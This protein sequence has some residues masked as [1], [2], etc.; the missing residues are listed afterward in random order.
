MQTAT[1][2]MI[3]Y[4]LRESVAGAWKVALEPECRTRGRNAAS[5]S[6]R[7]IPVTESDFYGSR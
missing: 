2:R 4:T 6:S 1:Q 3:R 5:K 7:L